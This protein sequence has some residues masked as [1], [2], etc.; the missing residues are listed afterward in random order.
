M[1]G[2]A[3]PIRRKGKEG[4]ALQEELSRSAFLEMLQG[5]MAVADHEVAVDQETDAIADS[6][7]PD[8]RF[9]YA[10]LLVSKQANQSI[11]RSGVKSILSNGKLGL[12]ARGA[13]LARL[14]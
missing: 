14:V 10:L 12:N 8:P 9:L 7:R 3:D 1:L 5:P 4:I 6:A 13:G 11:S 2:K